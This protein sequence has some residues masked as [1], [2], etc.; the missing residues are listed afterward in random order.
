M[1]NDAIVIGI[2]VAINIIVAIADATAMI[3]SASAWGSVGLNNDN[4]HWNKNI[5]S[6]KHSV[7]PWSSDL[8]VSSNMAL[9]VGLLMPPVKAEPHG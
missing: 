6:S 4:V 7:L 8:F 3:S 5:C 9:T 1:D 2:D